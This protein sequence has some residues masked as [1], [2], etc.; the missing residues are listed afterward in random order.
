MTIPSSSLGSFVP[1]ALALALAACGANEAES[2][3][4]PRPAG[5]TA[6]ATAAETREPEPP[7]AEEAAPEPPAEPEPEPVVVEAGTRLGPIRVGMTEDALRALGLPE[8]DVDP[9][10]RRYGPY[11]VFVEDG[12]VRRVEARMGDLERIRFGERTFE[13]GVHIHEL[14]DAFPECEWYE[15]GGERYRCAGGTLFVQTTHSLD[16][17]RYTLAVERR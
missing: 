3:V 9:R 1:V 4:S 11:R 7:A 14:R 8:S 15:G 17:A 2:P 5:P 6:Q 10:S 16:P 12:V 13:R